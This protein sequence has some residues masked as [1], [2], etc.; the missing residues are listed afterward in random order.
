V[1]EIARRFGSGV[2]LCHVVA[3]RSAGACDVEGAGYLYEAD[4]KQAEKTLAMLLRSQELAGLHPKQILVPGP[5]E[6]ELLKIIR[7]N[8]IDLLIAG[9]HGRTGLRKLVFGS[10]A[11]QM[12]RLVPCP[13]LSVGPELS[14]RGELKFKQILFPTDFSAESYKILPYIAVIANEYRA[15]VAVL[16]V[17]SERRSSNSQ[18]TDLLEREQQQLA[19]IIQEYLGD[20]PV[21]FLIDS[22]ETVETILR[23]ALT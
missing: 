14:T 16:H 18:A 21:E 22:G 9:T 17:L 3:P 12:C 5:L 8:K 15:S 13:V 11:A 19:R 7:E 23:I 6:E 1:A 10:V 4:K 20:L 2:S